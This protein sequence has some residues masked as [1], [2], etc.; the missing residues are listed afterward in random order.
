M[1]NNASSSKIKIWVAVIGGG[2]A[3][4]VAT[5]GII[6]II[7]Q[8]GGQDPTQPSPAQVQPTQP[9]STQAQPTNS[10]YFA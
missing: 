3:V 1:S 8:N 4:C 5:I 9:P 2:S 7:L 6:G 10:P